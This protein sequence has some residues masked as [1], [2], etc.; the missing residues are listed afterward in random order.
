VIIIIKKTIKNK[1]CLIHI[2]LNYIYNLP[3]LLGYPPVFQKIRIKIDKK[4]F[5]PVG[6]GPENCKNWKIKN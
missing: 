4:L 6:P 2:L 3:Y 5:K 1:L